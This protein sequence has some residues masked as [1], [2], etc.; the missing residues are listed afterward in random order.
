ML[1]TTP[2]EYKNTGTG[3]VQPHVC[4]HSC[5]A[6]SKLE[7]ITDCFFSPVSEVSSV[8]FHAEHLRHAMSF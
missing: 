8:L 1:R 7:N 6:Q 4:L 2:Y 5:A 3:A